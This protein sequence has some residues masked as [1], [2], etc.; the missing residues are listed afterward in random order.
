MGGN[1]EAGTG[2]GRGGAQEVLKFVRGGG[3][4]WGAGAAAAPVCCCRAA[5]WSLLCGWWMSSCVGVGRGGTEDVCSVC[6]VSMYAF[7]MLRLAS[8]VLDHHAV[9][10]F[11]SCLAWGG[12]GDREEVEAG[13]ESAT[14]RREA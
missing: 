5:F 2:R 12:G 8:G 11:L 10:L 4:G 13:G 1:K 14:S 9:P 3:V 6:C 7:F